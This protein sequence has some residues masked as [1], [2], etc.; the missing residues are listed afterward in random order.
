MLD[1]AGHIPL[2]RGPVRVAPIACTARP[3]PL[4]HSSTRRDDQRVLYISSPIAGHAQRERLHCRPVAPAPPGLQID[5]LAED[6]VHPGPQPAVNASIR[7][8]K[9]ANESG[10]IPVRRT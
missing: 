10:Q 4:P 5:W 7:R 6:P 9:S 8:A 3:A 2:A 1:G